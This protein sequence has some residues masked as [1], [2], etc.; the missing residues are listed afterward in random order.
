M[1]FLLLGGFLHSNPYAASGKS[2][3]IGKLSLEKLLQ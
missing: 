3:S 1:F 2:V